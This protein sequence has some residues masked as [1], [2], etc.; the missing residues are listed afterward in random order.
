MTQKQCANSSADFLIYDVNATDPE[1]DNFTFV[2][3]E[4]SINSDLFRV[5]LYTGR[6][7]TQSGVE[8]D[9]EVRS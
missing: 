6:V 8:L 1:G 2:I 3:P 9:R 5:E 7:F 4:N